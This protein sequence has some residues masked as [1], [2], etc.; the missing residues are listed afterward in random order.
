MRWISEEGVRTRRVNRNRAS[1]RRSFSQSYG[2][3]GRGCRL[4][5]VRARASGTDALETRRIPNGGGAS[6]LAHRDKLVAHWHA[7]MLHREQPVAAQGVMRHHGEQH[8]LRLPL[9][10]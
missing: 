1:M 9:P 4:A 7:D 8:I 10:P 6:L 5:T 2:R 3:F